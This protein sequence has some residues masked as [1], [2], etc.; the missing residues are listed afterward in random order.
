LRT[1]GTTLRRQFGESYEEYR[2]TVLRWI[3]RVSKGKPE[4]SPRRARRIT[5]EVFRLKSFMILG[6]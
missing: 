2:R 1:P 3:P 5:K 4:Q 6:G